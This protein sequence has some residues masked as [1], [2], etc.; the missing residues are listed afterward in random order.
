[1]KTNLV[2]P[3]WLV[4]ILISGSSCANAVTVYFD[5][6]TRGP[7]DTLQIGGV[8]VSANGFGLSSS[9]VE[10]VGGYGLGTTVLGPGDEVDGEYQY[11]PTQADTRQPSWQQEAVTFSVDGSINS[12]TLLPVFRAYADGVL[13]TDQCSFF[14]FA[15]GYGGGGVQGTQADS[16]DPSSG[17]PIMFSGANLLSQN[18]SP[19]TLSLEVLFDN[20]AGEPFPYDYEDLSETVNVEF[21]FTVVS[22]DYTP[23][24][25]PASLSVVAFGIFGITLLR[26]RK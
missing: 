12:I 1:M 11:L 26:R 17:N 15:E 21:G 6:A 14:F 10:T 23:A 2:I 20:V 3:K 8:T 22:L 16:I 5:D 19:S 25:E 24:P 9:Q 18:G 4:L 13:L 7:S